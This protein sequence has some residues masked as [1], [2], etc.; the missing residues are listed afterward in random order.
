MYVFVSSSSVSL[1]VL[2]SIHIKP[3][4]MICASANTWDNPFGNDHDFDD[5]DGMI[6]QPIL[7]SIVELFHM[8]NVESNGSISYSIQSLH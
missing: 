5:N 1:E 8:V 2:F 3:M 4:P 7:S 6:L